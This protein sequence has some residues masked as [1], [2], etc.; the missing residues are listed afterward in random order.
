MKVRKS[1]RKP[2]SRAAFQVLAD[3]LEKFGEVQE[4][5]ENIFVVDGREALL[6]AFSGQDYFDSKGYYWFSLA[7]TK[8]EYLSAWDR[9]HAWV[10]LIGGASGHYFIPFG[11]IQSLIIQNPSNRHDG[12]WDLYI[13]LDADRAYLGVTQLINH[14]DVTNQRHHFE[15]LWQNPALPEEFADDAIHIPDSLPLPERKMQEVVWV[16]R[17]TRQSRLVKQLYD[18]KCQICGWTAFSPRLK[19]RWYCEAHHVRPLGRR[20]NGP[21]H[22]SNLLALCPTHHCMMDLGI[23]AVE[24]SEL[25]IIVASPNEPWDGGKLNLYPEHRLKQE[26]LIFHLSNIYVGDHRSQEL[27]LVAN[28]PRL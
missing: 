12:R 7:K 18:Y 9:D 6:V 5:D 4:R 20:F 17:D 13:R 11:E 8:Y 16:V 27:L 2:E 22:I 23:L 25:N 19:N 10:V 24:P 3:F 21:D 14:A 26:H 28:T 15:Q 1:G